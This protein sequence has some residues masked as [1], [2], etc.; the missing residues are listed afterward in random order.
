M[1][2]TKITA[3]EGKQELFIEREFNAPREKVFAAFA[4]PEIL[5]QFFAP[6]DLTMHFNY[7]DYKTGGSYSWCNKRN[8]TTVCTFNGVIHELAAPE[9]IVQTSEYMDLPERGHVVLEIM[10]FEELPG[11]RTK[12]VIHDICPS[13]F[14]RDAMINSGME[15]GIVDIFNKLDAYF[16]H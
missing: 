2:T 13:V 5:T 15:R 3:E 9:R 14:V 8:G 10:R 11:N 7:H 6:F 1:S 16:G 4:D 12:L